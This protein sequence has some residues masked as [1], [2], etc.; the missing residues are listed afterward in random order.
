MVKGKK[1]TKNMGIEIKNDNEDEIE[2]LDM[3]TAKIKILRKAGI[4]WINQLTEEGKAISANQI[5]RNKI[6]VPDNNKF[7]K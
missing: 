6:K 7:K 4:L 5:D 1:D 3:N 2:K